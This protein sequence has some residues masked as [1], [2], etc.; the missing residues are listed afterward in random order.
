MDFKNIGQCVT[1]FRCKEKKLKSKDLIVKE[2]NQEY[3]SGI[4]LVSGEARITIKMQK[5]SIRKR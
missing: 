3:N 1:H 4:N 2:K 5:F